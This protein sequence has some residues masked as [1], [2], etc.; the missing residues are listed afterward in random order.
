MNNNEA[1]RKF[2]NDIF[3]KNK[4]GFKKI[5]IKF[6][7]KMKIKPHKNLFSI[8][9]GECPCD[10]CNKFDDCASRNLACRGFIN[11]VNKKK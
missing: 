5:N 3:S 7:N 9:L 1:T 4:D 8:T 10:L 2:Y 6:L 11:Y